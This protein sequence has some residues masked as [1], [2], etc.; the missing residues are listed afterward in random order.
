MA[1]PKQGQTV[2]TLNEDIDIVQKLDTIAA[3]EGTS[4]SALVR[5]AIRQM[6]FSVPNIPTFGNIPNEE[7]RHQ[8]PA[9]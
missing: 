6:L 2:V 7:D 3:D 4:R 9:A 5:R 8:R 1:P